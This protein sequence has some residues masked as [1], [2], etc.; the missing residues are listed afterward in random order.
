MFL[1]GKKTKKQQRT[2]S[3]WLPKNLDVCTKFC[4]KCSTAL[5]ISI[6]LVSVQFLISSR[7]RAVKLVDHFARTKTVA[8]S[9]KDHVLSFLRFRHFY[10]E[11]KA[12]NHI[13]HKDTPPLRNNGEMHFERL[14]TVSLLEQQCLV[15]VPSGQFINRSSVEAWLWHVIFCVYYRNLNREQN[16]LK[17]I[18]KNDHVT[19]AM[20][21]IQL[22]NTV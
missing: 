12:S 15:K 20:L 7:V 2:F 8:E 19:T 18:L 16:Q 4:T 3:R 13:S 14:L 10:C 1:K 11:K 9:V 6:I 22:I 5:A 17:M 21:T